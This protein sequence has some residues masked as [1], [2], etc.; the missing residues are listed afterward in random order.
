MNDPGS[1]VK[2]E[3]SFGKSIAGPVLLVAAAIVGALRRWAH[4]PDVWIA[5]LAAWT[6]VEYKFGKIS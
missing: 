1:Q 2:S 6:F 5:G 3:G 4:M